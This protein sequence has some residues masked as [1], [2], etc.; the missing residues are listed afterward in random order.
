MSENAE[1]RVLGI[2]G[3]L[4][5]DSVNRSLLRTAAE[6]A[7]AGVRVVEWDRLADVPPFNEDDEAA[8]GPVVENLR[9]AI[10][11][12]DAVLIC[13][14]E[15]NGSVPGQLKNALDWASRP[16]PEHVLRDKAVAVLG[17]SPSPAGAARAQAETRAV[18]ERL[19]ARV[20]GDEQPLPKAYEVV[21]DG[22][23]TDDEHRGTVTALLAELGGLRPCEY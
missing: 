13:T 23:V 22:R 21:E 2:A 16:F 19:G 8:P 6:V 17:A 3:S 5:A 18:L 9:A 14:P 1:V 12:A 7:P 20:V 10:E 4:R 15:Y 11:S